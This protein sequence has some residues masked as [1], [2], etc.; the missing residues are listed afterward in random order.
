MRF[1]Y[2][3]LSY[4]RALNGRPASITVLSINPMSRESPEKS[5]VHT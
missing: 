4:I 1:L 5:V 2:G 3:G